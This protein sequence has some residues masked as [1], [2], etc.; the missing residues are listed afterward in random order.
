MKLHLQAV[1]RQ[2]K[3]RIFSNER[4]RCNKH[5]PTRPKHQTS[6]PSPPPSLSLIHI[7]GIHGKP[8]SIATLLITL[9]VNCI[10]APELKY[11]WLPT[12]EL[13]KRPIHFF[14]VYPGR[15]FFCST[16]P[17]RYFPSSPMS[18]QRAVRTDGIKAIS[19]AFPGDKQAKKSANTRNLGQRT[20]Y[21][22]NVNGKSWVEVM[23]AWMHCRR[24]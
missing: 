10:M 17:S 14:P 7:A 23:I 3:F 13:N 12:E 5:P 11:A 20:L 22:N 1:L 19:S 24:P 9:C 15:H 4:P 8:V 18:L 2:I 21:L 6:A 16:P